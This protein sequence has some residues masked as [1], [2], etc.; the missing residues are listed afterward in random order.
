MI[1]DA[2]RLEL[3]AVESDNDRTKL[4]I[5]DFAN[6][7]E[8]REGLETI[9]IHEPTHSLAALRPRFGDECVNSLAGL[10]WARAGLCACGVEG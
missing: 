6:V 5:P 1:R 2:R 9:P 10:G 7:Q 8:I 4:V 3:E